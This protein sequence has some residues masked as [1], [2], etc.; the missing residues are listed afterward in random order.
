[1]REPFALIGSETEYGILISTDDGRLH[2]EGLDH[3]IKDRVI[4]EMLD[5]GISITGGGLCRDTETF[6]SLAEHSNAEKY[7]RDHGADNVTKDSMDDWK[8]FSQRRGYSGSLLVNGARFYED[9]LHPEYSCPECNDPYSALCAQKAGDWVVQHAALRAERFASALMHSAAT[10]MV[11][12]NNSDGL[13]HSYA[14]HEN[15]LVSRA[16]FP[17][18]CEITPESD[19]TILFFVTRQIITGAGKIGSECRAD[20]PFQISQRPDFFGL[21]FSFGTTGR[22]GIINLRD[23]P[24][25]NPTQWARFHVI[26]GD[27]NRSDLSL[28]LK[29]GMTALFFMM[30]ETGFLEKHFPWYGA[31][32][33][34]PVYSLR[35]VSCDLTL[36]NTLLFDDG[37]SVTALEV[38][39]DFA[40]C[41]EKFISTHSFPAVWQRVVT[42]WKGVLEGLCGDRHKHPLS[43]SLDWVAVEHVLQNRMKKTGDR[44]DSDGC[45]GLELSYRTLDDDSV[46]ARLVKHDQIMT[47]AEEHDVQHLITGT[48]HGTR[49]WFRSEIIKRYGNSVVHLKWDTIHFSGGTTVVLHDPL[50]GDNAA[51]RSLFLGDP[52]LEEF[53][54]RARQHT[55]THMEIYEPEKGEYY[56]G[57]RYRYRE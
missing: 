9:M 18:L 4:R 35:N 55:P 5:E 41:A 16:L 6:A 29:F 12:K 54:G 36:K 22:R 2:D 1:M 53:L 56:E 34:R 42:L 27:S 31:A 45:C 39:R 17:R 47:I 28:F 32:L 10:I 14:G 26:V 57:S 24:Y 30:L 23:V 48:P 8:R 15:Y 21:R 20:V 49:A 37:R 13:E 46:Y 50:W 43:R 25:A 38:M 52:S 3:C 51:A 7:M 44:F 11:A 40:E 19:A 33:Q